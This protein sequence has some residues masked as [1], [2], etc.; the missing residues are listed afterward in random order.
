[1]FVLV[2]GGREQFFD[3][4]QLSRLLPE[5]KNRDRLRNLTKK[6]RMM[7]NVQNQ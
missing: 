3:L 5:D 2:A 6:Y 1:V 7:D 4:A